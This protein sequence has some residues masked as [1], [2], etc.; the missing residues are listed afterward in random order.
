MN[1][2]ILLLTEEVI[3]SVTNVSDNLA[4][5]YLQSSIRESQEISLKGVLGDALLAKCKY[6]KGEGILNQYPKYDELVNQCQYFLSY[7]V[8]ADLA[9]KT[10]Y[11]ISNAG[12]VKTRDEFLEVATWNEIV[13]NQTYYEAKADAMCYQLQGWL[14]ENRAEFPELSENDCKRIKANLYSAATCGIWLGGSRGKTRKR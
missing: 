5:K 12:L 13:K 10:S 11:K 4:G 7:L 14:M 2:E 3:K 8:L 6:L 1:A 9:V